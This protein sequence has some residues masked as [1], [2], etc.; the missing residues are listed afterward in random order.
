MAENSAMSRPSAAFDVAVSRMASLAIAWRQ[1]EKR[2]N[3]PLPR[4]LR[5]QIYQYLLHSDY[6]RVER[7]WKDP[8]ATG[9]TNDLFERKD[10]RFHTNILAVNHAIHDEAQDYL[11]GGSFFT[12]NSYLQI[13]TESKAARMKHHSLRMHVA[14]SFTA[15]TQYCLLLLKDLDALIVTLR[16][17]VSQRLGLALMMEDNL[18]SSSA[19]FNVLGM[20]EHES[21][22]AMPCRFKVQFLDTPWRKQDAD[23]LTQRNVLDSLREFN[24][25]GMRVT[26]DGVLPE[27][28]DHAERV[29]NT[30]GAVLISPLALDWLHLDTYYKKKALAD[31]AV[32]AG[33]LGLAEIAYKILDVD[34]SRHIRAQQLTSADWP[35]RTPLNVLRLDV[36]LTLY[37]LEL[38]LDRFTKREDGTVTKR[39]TDTMAEFEHQ[40]TTGKTFDSSIAD[41][42]RSLKGACRHF[43]LLKEPYGEESRRT[44]PTLAVSRLVR[45]FS[46]CVHLPYNSYDLAILSQVQNQKAPARKH[47]P[48]KKCSVFMLEPQCFNFHQMPAVPKKLDYVVGMQNLQVLRNLDDA[49]KNSVNSIERQLGPNTTNW[50]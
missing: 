34:M 6:T 14:K 41:L 22:G 27:H 48:K 37:Y 10:Y 2:P 23:T 38:K 26:F 45:K 13:V 29:K 33:E 17:Q 1:R 47:L 18:T 49:T 25:T 35:T 20:N 42:L 11:H 21:N 30:M 32:C 8:N 9:E 7:K 43:I 4:E 24:C 31:K 5:D 3:F 19:R 44:E 50:D 28:V 12:V 40:S 36:L 15:A 46:T 16:T 39:L